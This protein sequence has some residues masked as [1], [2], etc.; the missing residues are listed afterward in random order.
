[1]A[2]RSDVLSRGMRIIGSY[3]RTHPVPFT[4]AVTGA[5]LYAAATVGSTIVLGKVTDRVIMPAF[6]GGVGGGAVLAGVIAIMAVAVVRASGIVLR[7]YFAGMT[8]SRMQRS[9]RNQVVDKYR[10]LP[11]AFHRAQPTG[12]LMAHAEADVLAATEVLHPLPYSTAVILLIVFATIS[13]FL[14]D[15]VLALIGILVLPGLVVLSRIY[16]AQ[17]ER[18]VMQAQERIGEL[19]AVAHESLDGAL[20]V[21][22]LGREQ[23]EVARLAERAEALRREKVRVGDI[24][25]RWEPGLDALPNLG[26]ILLLAVGALRV[27]DG[28]ITAGQLVQF[29]SLFQLLAF[30]LRVIGFALSDVPRAVAGRARLEGVFREPVTLRHA[31]DG[32]ALPPGPLG[33]SVSNVS[34]GYLEEP[35]L[36]EVSFEIRPNESVAIAGPTGS[37]KSTLAHLLVRL[38][39]PDRG[40]VRIGGVDVRTLAAERLR[41]STA[42]VF[43]ESFLFATTIRENIDLGADAPVEELERAARLAQAHRFIEALP[44]GYDT[45]VGERGVTLSGGQRQRVALARA[46]L[47]RPRVLILDDATSSVDSTIEAAILDGLRRE[48]DATLVV[49]AY[50]VSA[51]ALADRV[52]FLDRRGIAAEGTHRELLSHPAYEAMV[53]AYE[54]GAA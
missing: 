37:G 2:R 53:R 5:S 21:K 24:R 48:L 14:T 29:V 47:R 8:A 20:V 26:I 49:V 46:L 6:H 1:M 54:M 40:G 35:V 30:P 9:L 34:F 31:P 51:I 7:R 50:R 13:L 44:N 32:A 15:W 22:T 17:E 16:T 28:R 19:S 23:A 43:Q 33:I 25:A 11:L 38:A 27:S 52:L 10:D 4:I 41:E 12:E 45:A 42:I 39:D 3:V 18:P 36:E